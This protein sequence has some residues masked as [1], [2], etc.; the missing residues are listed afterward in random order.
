MDAMN[1]KNLKVD[2]DRLWDSLMEMAKI[3]PGVAGGN[4]RLALSDFDREGRDLFVRWCQEAGCSIT[5]DRMG[6]IFARRPGTDPSLPPVTTGSHLDTQPTGGKFDGVFGVLAGLEVIRTLNDNGIETAAP[7]EVAVWTNEEG[8][9]F[10]PAMVASGVFAGVFDLDYGHSRADVDGKTIGEEL[11]RIGYL[12]DETPGDHPIRAFFEAHIEQGPILEAEKKTIGVVTGAQG[13][14]WFEV[15]LTGSE[16]HAGT[17]PMNRRRDALVAAAKL[18]ATVNE[19]AL[20]HPPHAVSTVGM[21]QVSPNSRN[22]IPGSVFLTVDLRHPEDE[23]LSKMEAELRQACAAICG[24]AR[25]DAD[26][27]MIWYS[28]PIVFDKDCVGA[29]KQAASTAGYENME[30]VS[31]AG[32]DACYVSRVAPTAMIFVPCEEG[33]S[34]NEAESATPEDL[35]AGCNVLLYAM[36]ERASA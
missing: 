23:T 13:Q 28:P 9:R 11:K 19:I 7:I 20:A 4:C 33:V 30:I 25:I 10:A 24:P 22:T 32:H 6:N 14:R 34:H 18:I 29:V 17:T 12:G 5:V 36:L 8:S 16:S 1:P 31:G 15:T 26:V 35:A 2:G 27:E 21:M 3:G